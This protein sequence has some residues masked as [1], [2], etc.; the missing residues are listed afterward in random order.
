MSILQIVPSAKQMTIYGMY[1]TQLAYKNQDK[2][3]PISKNV[4]NYIL[5]NS[6]FS[7]LYTWVAC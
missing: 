3:N 1:K 6:F 5:I 4:I 2:R 7:Q